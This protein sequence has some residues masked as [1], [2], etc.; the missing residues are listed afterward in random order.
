MSDTNETFSGTRPVSAAHAFDVQVLHGWLKDHIPGY[1]GPLSVEMFKGGQSNPTYR[2]TAASAR[3]VM[4]S[5][6]GPAAKLLPS[7]HAIDRE[8]RVMTALA[9]AGRFVD[10]FI[11]QVIQYN[12]ISVALT[13]WL[14]KY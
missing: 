14:P 9:K 1:E 11:R 12:G 4:R 2:L 13:P 7:A 3:Y 5:K 6:P 10:Q 8:Y